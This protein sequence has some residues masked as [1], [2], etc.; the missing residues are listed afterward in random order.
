MTITTGLMYKLQCQTNAEPDSLNFVI[1]SMLYNATQ[2][3]L[4]NL[5]YISK[6]TV[7]DFDG[8]DIIVYCNWN[9]SK[10]TFTNCSI[11]QGTRAYVL[12]VLL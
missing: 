5:T 10:G 7:T 9:V 1:D 2:Q 3:F 8:V 11:I 6:L 4:Q 12:N